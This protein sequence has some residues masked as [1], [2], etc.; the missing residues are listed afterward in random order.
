M[1]NYEYRC[2]QCETI[3]ETQL[4]MVDYLFPETQPC[5]ECHAEKCLHIHLTSAP[6]LGDAIKLGIKKP[7]ASWTN[8]VLGKIQNNVPDRVV[9]GSDGKLHVKNVS[10]SKSRYSP[11]RS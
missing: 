5:P 3:F 11:G 2:D 8:D 1:P 10:F 9:R 6:A 7:P 4:H